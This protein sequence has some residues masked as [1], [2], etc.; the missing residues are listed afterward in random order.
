MSAPRPYSSLPPWPARRP[1][2]P[3]GPYYAPRRW[4][5]AFPAG[6]ARAGQIEARLAQL[7][8]PALAP[9]PDAPEAKEPGPV[10]SSTPLLQAY[11]SGAALS[12]ARNTSDPWTLWQARPRSSRYAPLETIFE[13]TEDLHNDRHGGVPVRG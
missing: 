1:A 9:Y 5:D 8:K 4:G 6:V 10:S 11:A 3:I 7:R 13:D 2:Q 12:G